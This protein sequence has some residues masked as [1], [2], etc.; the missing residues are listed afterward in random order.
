MVA[1][2]LTR[3]EIVQEDKIQTFLTGVYEWS[4][5][6]RSLLIAFFAIFVLSILGSYFWQNYEMDRSEQIQVQFAEALKIYHAPVIEESAGNSE[7]PIVFDEYIF[8]RDE[9][10]REKAL[11]AFTAVAEDYSGTHL[12]L[13]ARYYRGLIKQEMGQIGTAEEDLSF[14]MGNSAEPQTRSLARHLLAR[15]AELKDDRQGATELL[16]EILLEETAYFPKDTILLRLAQNHEAAGNAEEAVNFYTRL[17]TEYPISD[18]S[19]EAQLRLDQ[20]EEKQK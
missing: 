16:E 9:E 5:Q 7:D 13:L 1:K 2:R 20:L 10:R 19:Q 4:S 12:G 3:R 14:V 15:I 6:N 8:E 18:Y 17:T 11:E